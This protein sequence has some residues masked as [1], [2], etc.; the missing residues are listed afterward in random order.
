MLQANTCPLEAV[1]MAENY[2]RRVVAF[3]GQIFS[4]RILC[5][6]PEE[7][8]E[9]MQTSG[10]RL[11]PEKVSTSALTWSHLHFPL[12]T[13]VEVYEYRRGILGEQYA[14]VSSLAQAC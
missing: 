5:H 10:I 7:S 3:T 6:S 2:R 8:D 1:P 11:R 9:E 4:S 13:P 12:D 14:G